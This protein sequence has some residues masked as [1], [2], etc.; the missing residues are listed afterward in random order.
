M[1]WGNWLK[2]STDWIRCPIGEQVS[3]AMENKDLWHQRLGHLNTQQLSKMVQ[4][5]LVTGIKKVSAGSESDLPLCEGC[6][7]G[8]MQRKPFKSVDHEQSTKKLG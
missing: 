4:Q 2:S 7:V 8:K 5:N 6:I 3:A 1:V